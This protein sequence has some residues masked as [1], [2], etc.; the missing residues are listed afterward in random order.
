M[1]AQ[2][3]NST[4]RR[5]TSAALLMCASLFFLFDQL[6]QSRSATSQQTFV[7]RKGD[8]ASYLA[9]RYYGYFN[10]SLFAV[11]Q[12]A[13]HHISDL[14]LI[15]AGDTLFLPP[16]ASALPPAEVLR[17]AAA[18]AVL[19]FA[20]G[21][22]R[23]RRG[24]GARAFA[25]A[26]ANLILQP[27]DELETGAD[28]R[29]EL[30]LDNR[31]V[32]RLAANSRLRITA[33]QRATPARNNAQPYQASFNLSVGSLWT[34]VTLFLD[35]PP[36]IEVKLPT[37][38]AGVQGTVYRAVVAADSATSVRVYEG[39]VRVQ[40]SPA[41]G[42]PQR[43]GPPQQIPGPQQVPVETWIKMVQAYQELVIAKNGKPGEP[44]PFQDRGNDLAWVRWNQERD[45]DLAA[46]R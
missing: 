30:V 3:K 35:K 12:Q 8:T 45:R 1:P 39:R 9:M 42:A 34:R 46:L 17:S 16:R 19:T 27:S 15:H 6:P 44:R 29:A 23:Y 4:V 18:T 5:S 11:L 14:N 33:L 28:G 25:P 31:S 41:S 21:T 38:I 22:V 43:I 37:A 13:N 10:D 20:E 7:V 2:V 40:A 26:P 24:G 36:K 32:M